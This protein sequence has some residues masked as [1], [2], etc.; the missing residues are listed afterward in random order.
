[1]STNYVPYT[2]LDKKENL[3]KQRKENIKRKKR[4]TWQTNNINNYIECK[5][6]KDSNIKFVKF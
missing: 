6:T 5:Y 3:N 1:M 4:I 2:V